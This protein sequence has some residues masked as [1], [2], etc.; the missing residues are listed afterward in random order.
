[1]IRCVAW[2]P[3]GQRLAT[4]SDDGTV[5]IWDLL[6][7]QT[8]YI[9][10]NPMMS[11]KSVNGVMNVAWSPNGRWSA[12][13]HRDGSVWISEYLSR[14]AFSIFF[15]VIRNTVNHVAWSPTGQRLATSSA[16]S[17]AC[18]W[19]LAGSGKGS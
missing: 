18:I 14:Q 6:S 9:L 11:V 2:S 5:R 17:T 19:F 8:L 10:R 15:E 12:R 4:S 1:M 7:G 13:L 16:D 3:N